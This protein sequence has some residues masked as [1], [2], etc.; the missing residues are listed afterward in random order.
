LP[1]IGLKRHYGKGEQGKPE[2]QKTTPNGIPLAEIGRKQEKISPL[3]GVVK[4]GRR[5]ARVDLDKIV[6]GKRFPEKGSQA[7]KEGNCQR[8]GLTEV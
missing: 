6:P 5:R 4:E 2:R 1:K 3:Q 8:G 7:G